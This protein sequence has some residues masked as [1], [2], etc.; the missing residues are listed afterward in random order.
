[1]S[2]NRRISTRMWRDE[3]FNNLS[4]LEKLLFVYCLTSPD[5]SL[6]GIYEVPKS[7]ISADTGIEPSKIMTIFKRFETDNKIIYKNGW[8]AIKNF[9]KY[10]NY[11]IPMQK[12]ADD[13]LIRVRRYYAFRHFVYTTQTRVRG[14][15][16][17]YEK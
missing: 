8:I 5:T 14:C 10:Q 11:N 16:T 2:K 7:I 4:P 17:I 6:C 15:Q 3:Y 12:N 9:M 1:M 13:D